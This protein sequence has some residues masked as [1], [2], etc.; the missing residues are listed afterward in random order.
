MRRAVAIPLYVIAATLWLVTFPVWLSLVLT[1]DL[2]TG[3]ARRRPRSRALVFIGLYLMSEL[4]GIVVATAIWIV[5]LGGALGG[6]QRFVRANATLQRWWTS[7][8]FFGSV[9]IYGA[10]IEIEGAE[11]ID[12]GPLLFFVR[13][14][15]AADAVLTAALVANPRRLLLRYVLKRELTWDPCLDI[16]G[17]RLPNAFVDRKAGRARGAIDAI[18]ELARGLTPGSAVLIYPEGTRFTRQK[19][20]AAVEGLK[21]GRHEELARIAAGLRHVLPP[22]LGGPL[23]LLENAVGVD[24]VFVEHMGFEGTAT[25]AAFWKGEL[26]GATIRVRLRRFAAASIPAVGRDAWLFSRWA[27]LDQW[28]DDGK[29]TGRA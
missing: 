21:K 15:S 26:V 24:V 25:L 23:A 18:A 29:L 19:L 2:V 10:H 11:Q 22:R 5:L 16:V 6:R 14:T 17:R 7:R 13:H 1:L 4:I 20:A 8:L 28:L 3:Q 9:A 12:A 27:E